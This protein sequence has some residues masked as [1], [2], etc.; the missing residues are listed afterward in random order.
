MAANGRTDVLRC[1]ALFLS[2]LHL[3]SNQCEAGHLAAFLGCIQPR[4]LFL[5]GDIIDLQAIRFNAHADERFLTA[6]IDGL[7]DGK[8][9]GPFDDESTEASEPAAI[10]A[11]GGAE[12][13]AGSAA[14]RD[15]DH[16]HPRQPRRLLPAP[17]RLEAAWPRDPPASLVPHTGRAEVAGAPWR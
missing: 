3:G 1:D 10:V 14:R 13:P 11:P 15:A 4:Q 9:E 16:L 6:L 12:R 2:D 5:V 17:C 7:I 8:G